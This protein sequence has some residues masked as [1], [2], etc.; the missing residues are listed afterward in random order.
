MVQSAFALRVTQTSCGS[1]ARNPLTKVSSRTSQTERATASRR[2]ETMPP[3]TR[4]NAGRQSGLAHR[5][6]SDTRCCGVCH[7]AVHFVTLSLLLPGSDARVRGQ[8]AEVTS[9][10]PLISRSAQRVWSR[11]PNAEMGKGSGRKGGGRVPPRRPPGG[12][13]E[14]VRER[15]G[16]RGRHQPCTSV[17][18]IA[19]SM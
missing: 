19:Q 7:S 18:H 12:P 3:C 10:V 11:S 14:R 4:R 16:V 2:E 5:R 9:E 8:K 6:G 15:V 17:D 1:R 13:P